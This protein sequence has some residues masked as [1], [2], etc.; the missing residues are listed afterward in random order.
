MTLLAVMAVAFATLHLLVSGT[1]IRDRLVASLGEKAYRGLFSL[2]SAVALGGLIWSYGLQTEPQVTS[3]YEWRWLGAVMMVPAVA[4]IVLG[5][6]TPGP[7]LVGAERMLLKDAAPAGI[8]RVTRHPFLWGVALWA[9][10]HLGFNPGTSHGLF[11]GTF[12]MVAVAGTFSIDAKRAR[13]FGDA[14]MRYRS[15]TSNLP[16]AALLAGRSTMDWKGIGLLRMLAVIGAYAGLV[17]LHRPA[18]GVL[19][20]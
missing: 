15:I 17:V 13:H 20:F 11:F 9:V 3:F 7:T 6:L 14:W 4:L 8:H 18:F 5:L 10:V 16:F 19:P 2:A 12:L 1:R